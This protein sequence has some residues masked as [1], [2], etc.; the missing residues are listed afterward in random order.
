MKRQGYLFDKIISFEN[1][2]KASRK[3]QRGKHFKNST[4]DFN[5]SLEPELLKLQKE[6]RERAYRMG[7]YKQFYIYDPKKRLISALPYRDRV[8]QHALCNIIEP[9]FDNGLIYD[10]Y[11]CRKDKGSHRAVNRFTTYCRKNKYALKCDIKSYFASINHDVLFEMIMKRIKD[12]GALWLIKLIIDSTPSPGIPIGNLASQIFANLYLNGL[13]HYLKETVKCKHYIR[14]MDDL[15]VFDNDKNR[16]SEIKEAIREY[17]RR[18]KLDLHPHKSQI[19]LTANG[20]GFLGYKVYPTHRL[21]VSQNVKRLRKR[22][23]KYIELLKLK[24]ITRQKI[25]CSI[26]SWLGYAIHA[27]SF[28]LRRR[29]L[30]EFALQRG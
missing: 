10:T 5:L 18:L 20:I 26:Q 14:Y 3:A 8:V 29:L 15:I 17:L 12:P 4:A 16:L 2:L 13:D 11:A 25:S 21:I 24:L 22:L 28:N 27:D 23:K 1:L 30:A 7:S 6:L 9:I 19:Y